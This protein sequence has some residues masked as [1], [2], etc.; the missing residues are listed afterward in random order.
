MKQSPGAGKKLTEDCKKE[1]DAFK[2]DRAT[3]VN[4]NVPLGEISFVLATLGWCC[5]SC[6]LAPFILAGSAMGL[7][8]LLSVQIVVGLAN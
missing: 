4:K 7:P 5:P 6:Y 1:M 8:C 2:I 3:N